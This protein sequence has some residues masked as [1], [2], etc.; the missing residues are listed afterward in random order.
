MY[1][2]EVTVSIY[3][4]PFLFFYLELLLFIEVYF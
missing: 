2:T 1:I 4:I 3:N